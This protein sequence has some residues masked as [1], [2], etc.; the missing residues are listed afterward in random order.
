MIMRRKESI[1]YVFFKNS[2][3]TYVSYNKE[4]ITFILI[5]LFIIKFKKNRNATFPYNE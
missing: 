5:L 3:P 2:F 4:F 1:E